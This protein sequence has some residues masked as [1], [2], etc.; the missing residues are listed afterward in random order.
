[1]FAWKS[2]F[3]VETPP[4]LSPELETV[5]LMCTTRCVFGLSSKHPTVRG[6]DNWI[7]ASPSQ[8]ELLFFF[9]ILLSCIAADVV[10]SVV[11]FLP[12]MLKMSWPIS[13]TSPAFCFSSSSLASSC[14]LIR[15]DTFLLFFALPTSYHCHVPSSYFYHCHSHHLLCHLTSSC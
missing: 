2:N 14:F 10:A 5:A 12:L 7:S 15:A 4:P 6:L 1:M 8:L 13:A 3:I 11:A 9:G